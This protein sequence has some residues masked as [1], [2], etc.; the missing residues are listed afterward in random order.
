MR[1]AAIG[2]VVAGA[3]VGCGAGTPIDQGDLLVL[4]HGLLFG[5][6]GD[7]QRGIIEVHGSCV[8]FVTGLD[9]HIVIWPPDTRV[10]G[11]PG[12]YRFATGGVA[13]EQ[14]AEVWMT[15]GAYTEVDEVEEL[16]GPIDNRCSFRS[17]WL[18]TS[19]GFVVAS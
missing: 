3:V 6:P 16:A 13:V 11:S 10:S 12:A 2:L 18:A 5:G 9:K 19:V 17:Y 7:R 1:R 15:G 14:G 4:R 8:W